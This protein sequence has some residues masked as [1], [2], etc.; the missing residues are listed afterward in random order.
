M[1]R[2]ATALLAC[3][4]PMLGL[5]ASGA[6]AVPRSATSPIKH[7]VVLLQENH[8]FNDLLGQLCISEGNRCAASDTGTISDGTMIA[9][10]TE[11]DVSP[12]AGH[13]PADQ[14]AAIH[15]GAMDGWDHVGECD[16]AHHY[17]CLTQVP[18]GR[19]P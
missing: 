11:R 1:R 12:A 13:E 9:L 8:S 10:R 14:L 7:V 4:L 6:L 16:A 15:G 19:V 3:A 17:Q 2:T 18:A 5:G